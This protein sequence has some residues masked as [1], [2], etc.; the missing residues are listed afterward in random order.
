MNI[1]LQN[2]SVQASTVKGDNLLT[3]QTE[4]LMLIIYAHYTVSYFNFHLVQ[5]CTNCIC[6]ENNRFSNVIKD[7]PSFTFI[8]SRHK[9]LLCTGEG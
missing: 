5:P 7:T 9:I 8:L 3:F 4:M 6:V 1:I 2:L